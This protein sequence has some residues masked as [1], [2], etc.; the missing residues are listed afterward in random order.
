MKLL[1]SLED[2]LKRKRTSF[3]KFKKLNK[4]QSYD[5]VLKYCLDRE[6]LP[7]TLE[8]YKELSQSTETLK[9]AEVLQI[10]EVSPI[11][12][13]IIEKQDEPKSQRKVRKTKISS[14]TQTEQESRNAD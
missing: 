3:D 5:D 2:Y 4:I 12:E 1:I 14:P 13:N 7:I 9:S 6:C 11:I 10:E 8:R